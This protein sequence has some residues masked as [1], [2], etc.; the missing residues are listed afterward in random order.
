[1]K[2]QGS[3]GAWRADLE[4]KQQEQQA[5]LRALA[6]RLDRLERTATPA[7]ASSTL[8]TGAAAKILGVSKSRVAKLAL[9]ERLGSRHGRIWRLD[10]A[11]VED[12]RRRREA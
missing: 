4:R 7:N 1:M 12:L 6:D 8:S 9:I 11:K 5:A 2:R 10:P 3:G